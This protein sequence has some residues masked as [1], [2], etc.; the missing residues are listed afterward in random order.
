MLL[1]LGSSDLSGA[2]DG[3]PPSRTFPLAWTFA[4]RSGGREISS[5]WNTATSRQ[6][7]CAT[8]SQYAA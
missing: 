8:R 4:N 5:P 3:I 2:G 1:S 6:N 7:A